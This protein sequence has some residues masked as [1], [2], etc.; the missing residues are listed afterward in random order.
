MKKPINE[1]KRMQQLAGIITESEYQESQLD[2]GKAIINLTYN[3]APD[4]LEYVKSILK[5]AGIQSS[6]K[7][8][9]FDEIEIKVNKEDEAKARK[10][11]QSKGG[12]DLQ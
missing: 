4:D 10:V 2:E 12:F 6:V 8:G 5:K 1:I 3:T 9:N 7:V 11:L